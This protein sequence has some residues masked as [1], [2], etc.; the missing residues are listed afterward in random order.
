VEFE[1]SL[2]W[3]VATD[4]SIVVR[5]SEESHAELFKMI[6]EWELASK[7]RIGVVDRMKPVVGEV[8][9]RVQCRDYG[10]HWIIGFW[11]LVSDGRFK[12]G[13]SKV[14]INVNTLG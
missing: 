2:G 14:M 3:G 7:G 10:G 13:V 8:R 5:V 1:P 6:D 11:A 12:A 4:F 9:L